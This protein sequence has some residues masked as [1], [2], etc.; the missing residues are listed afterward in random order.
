MPTCKDCTWYYR[1]DCT[2]SVATIDKPNLTDI[3][4][5]G[6]DGE[7][8]KKFQQKMTM[9]KESPCRNCTCRH[10]ACHNACKAY[11][12]W[13]FGCDEQKK[14]EKQNAVY[15]YRFKS[16]KSCVRSRVKKSKE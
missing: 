1:G 10:P 4:H 2:A 12:D 11:N 13:K 14:A 5:V 7:P 3:K 15:E 8:C 9:R 6:E 16:Y